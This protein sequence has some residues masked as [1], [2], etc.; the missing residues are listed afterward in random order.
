MASRLDRLTI[1]LTL[2]IFAGSTFAT[3]GKFVDSEIT[4]KFYFTIFGLLL[5]LFILSGFIY[6]HNLRKGSLVDS[7]IILKGVFLIVMAQ[8]IYG[9][10]QYLTLFPSNHYAFSITGSFEN[11]T[12]FSA[13]LSISFP[14]G[15]FLSLNSKKSERKLYVFCLVIVCLALFLSG[16]RSGILSIIT[17]SLVLLIIHSDSIKN[18]ILRKKRILI[19]IVFFLI[20]L[21]IVL[22]YSKQNSATS[23]LYIWKISTEIIK[24]KPIL[25]HGYGKFKAVFMDY[26]AKYFISNPNSSYSF[27]ADNIKHPFNEFLKFIVE[28]GILGF[29]ILLIL[30]IF[31][32]RKVIKSANK[33]KCI[34]ISGMT[35]FLTFAFFSYPLQYPPI[36][37]LLALYALLPFSLNVSYY[38]CLSWFIRPLILVICI[39]GTIYFTQKMLAEMRW[40]KISEKSLDGETTAM[41]P[42]YPKLKAILK[43]NP[44][45]LYNYGAELNVAGKYSESIQV[46]KECKSKF[47]DY[48]L[49]MLLA[50]NYYNIGEI[51]MSIQTYIY[52]SNMIPCRFLPLYHLFDIYRETKQDR[53]AEKLA[54]NIVNKKVKIPSNTIRQI[55]SLAR[56]YLD[57]Q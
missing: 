52:A 32:F 57:S 25:G 9:L 54:L 11:P 21:A 36:W 31:W 7:M 8:C 29:A 20:L 48:D 56:V 3:S 55:K 51:D 53:K 41:L 35:A 18:L 17:S 1:V 49:Q 30:I 39:F 28:F 5:L 13:V 19:L 34:S 42:E 12:G 22:F 2:A 26:Q 40:K 38:K 43:S 10:L 6:G 46:L 44:Y 37:L 14:I 24:D 15:L 45:F 50:D 4:P 23:R 47:N 16:S 27:F 33:L